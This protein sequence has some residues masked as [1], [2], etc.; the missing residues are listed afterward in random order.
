MCDKLSF[1][2]FF[3][4]QKVVNNAMSIGRRQNRHRATKAPKRVYRCPECGKVHLTSKKKQVS[5]HNRLK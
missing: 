4:A 2:S 3:E 1:D 5:K